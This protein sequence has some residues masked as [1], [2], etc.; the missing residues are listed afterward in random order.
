MAMTG[1][2]TPE[3]FRLYPK[4]TETQRLKAAR[5]RRIFVELEERS[6]DKTQNGPLQSTQN[7]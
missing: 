2:A 5:L 7:E 4:R 6:G 1:H 3:A